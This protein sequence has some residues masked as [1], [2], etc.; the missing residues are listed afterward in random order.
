MS[1]WTA[2]SIAPW[3]F[4]RTRTAARERRSHLARLRL[5]PGKHTVRVV[6]RGEPYGD[7]KGTNISIDD[8]ILF[9]P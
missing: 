1:T 5:K 3:T 2:S 6:V 8:A 7:S 9:R 4:I